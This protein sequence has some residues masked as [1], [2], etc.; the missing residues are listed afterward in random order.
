MS[1]FKKF[2]SKYCNFCTC[3]MCNYTAILIICCNAYCQWVELEGVIMF[4]LICYELCLNFMSDSLGKYCSSPFHSLCDSNQ[5]THVRTH[6]CTY[7]HTHT[8][9]TTNCSQEFL[10]SFLIGKLRNFWGE[11]QQ[12]SVLVLIQYTE[13]ELTNAWGLKELSLPCSGQS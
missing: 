5:H 8:H 11:N 7:T 1:Q 2:W 12:S 6:A 10:Q 13:L 9:T 3:T 4:D